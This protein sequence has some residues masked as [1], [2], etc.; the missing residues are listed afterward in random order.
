M[1]FHLFKFSFILSLLLTLGFGEVGGFAGHRAIAAEPPPPPGGPPP[2]PGGPPPPD[3]NASGFGGRSPA[4][5]KTNHSEEDDYSSTPFT[6]YGEFNEASDEESDAKFFQYG[7]FFGVSLGLGFQF[8]DGYRGALWQGGFPMFDFKLHYW[9]DFNVALDVGFFTASQYYDTKIQNLGHVD[10]NLLHVGVDIKYYFD[11]K[12]LS[13]AIS[14]ANPYVLL[15]A[16]SF[17]KTENSVAQQSQ[18]SDNSL[19]ISAGG[20][21]EFVISPRKTYFEIESK[22]HFVTYKDTYTTRF[23]SAGLPSL[24]GNFFTFSGNL[25]FTW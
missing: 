8:I 9:F 25:L 5:S 18:D 4:E 10:I 20:G 13:S 3:G 15:G 24:T 21:F 14:F 1:K 16:G 12:N 2:G 22:I 6:E 11:T 19:G 17:S 23:S 7:R